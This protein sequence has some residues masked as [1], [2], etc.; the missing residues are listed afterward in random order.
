MIVPN[1]FN[2]NDRYNRGDRCLPFGGILMSENAADNNVVDEVIA[3]PTAEV[4][5]EA[6]EP[7]VEEQPAMSRDALLELVADGQ[8][9][10]GQGRAEEALMIAESVLETDP[11][12]VAG[13]A[14]KGDALERLG[15]ITDALEAY[16]KVIELK[17]DSTLDRIRASHLRKL[18]SS[19]DDLAVVPAVAPKRQALIAAGATFLVFTALCASIYLATR[20]QTTAS[21]TADQ[22]GNKPVVETFPTVAP[23][24]TGPSNT[25]T[26][27]TLP[28]GENT[29]VNTPVNNGPTTAVS[30]NPGYTNRNLLADSGS[31]VLGRPEDDGN[32]PLTPPL[33]GQGPLSITPRNDGQ[34]SNTTTS[35]GQG[36]NNPPKN[37]ATSGGNGG[38]TNPDPPVLENKKENSDPGTIIIKPSTG[39]NTGQGS[40]GGQPV[41]DDNDNA[42]SATA[43]IAVARDAFLKGEYARAA[44]AYEKALKAGATKGATYQRLAQCYDKLGRKA[45]AI[46]AYERAI[47][48]FQA[49]LANGSG[50]TDRINTAI[51]SC[52]TALKNLRGA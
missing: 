31:R 21:N 30:A 29:T 33:P 19:T 48:A 43:L 18:A 8:R 49:M 50:D 17:P 11:E 6:V 47:A 36:N 9:V 13:L 46:N 16:E 41:K 10:L 45:D 25:S 7:S 40:T 38:Q 44:D 42:K 37:N 5:A 14:L 28:P 39:G 22:T 2:L 4:Q 15:R 12:F 51:E 27:S 26:G 32:Q 24:P 3:E 1:V 23:V 20:P 35:G 34:A 52:R